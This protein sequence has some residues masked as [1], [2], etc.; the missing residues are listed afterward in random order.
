MSVV[1]EVGWTILVVGGICLVAG[2][3]Q[4]RRRTSAQA[5]AAL[6]HR[7]SALA[8]A[9][10][11]LTCGD[12]ARTADG[13]TAWLAGVAVPGPQGIGQSPQ[14]QRPYLWYYGR[15]SELRVYHET[16][17]V[18]VTDSD[19][20]LVMVREWSSAEPFSVEDETGRVEIVPDRWTVPDFRER[21]A[22]RRL[23]LHETVETKALPYWAAYWDAPENPQEVRVTRRGDLR[24][25]Y[26]EWVVPV[27]TP[28]HLHGTLRTDGHGT[29]ME[30][31]YE[32]PITVSVQDAAHREVA[33][34]T[35][36]DAR[37]ARRRLR[38]SAKM[39]MLGAVVMFVG[40]P[41]VLAHG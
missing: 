27:R 38:G 28:L 18:P 36:E 23:G 37:T 41:L 26:E 10:T 21:L 9:R 20:S 25:M 32:R 12:A 4:A 16:G 7:Q 15:V 33:Q 19:Y 30:S 3:I 11:D 5:D 35:R 2:I 6:D 8:A 39:I 29:R 24:Y 40:L 13:Q 31:G 22:H 34:A 14:S 1:H 17:N